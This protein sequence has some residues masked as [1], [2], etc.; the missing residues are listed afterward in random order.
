MNTATKES[1]MDTRPLHMTK[2]LTERQILS[3]VKA[4]ATVTATQYVAG[5][6]RGI[7]GMLNEGFVLY[8]EYLTTA[9]LP[10]K[11]SR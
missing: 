1:K 3:L 7:T 6:E 11:R 9:K 10:R 4:G 2:P 5:L 8:A